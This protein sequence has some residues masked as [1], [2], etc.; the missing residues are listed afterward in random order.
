M[1]VFAHVAGRQNGVAGTNLH[2]PV[3]A[4][5]GHD[6]VADEF[7]DASAR[8]FDGMAHFGKVTVQD[9]NRVI[10][11]A[12]F[13]QLGKAPD[14][15]KQHDD[16]ALLPGVIIRPGPRIL[17]TCLRRRQQGRHFQ[18]DGGDG[19]TGEPHI[20]RCADPFQN[21]GFKLGGRWQGIQSAADPHPAGRTASP[22]AADGGVRDAGTPAGL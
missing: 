14:I 13:G 2:A 18:V 1:Q 10:G 16:V 17:D 6:A 8:A 20:V 5:Q 21:L 7:V 22:A 19:L 3:D 11:Q 9:E 4:E 12:L 15:G